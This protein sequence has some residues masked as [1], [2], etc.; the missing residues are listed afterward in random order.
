[1]VRISGAS[2]DSIAQKFGAHRDAIWR[3]M[4]NHVSED[5]KAAYL[6]DAPLQEMAAKAAAEGV[7]LIHYFSL[8]RSTVVQQ[9][10][11][12]ASVNDRHGLAALSGRAI[13]VTREVGKLTGELM[14]FAPGN[15]VNNLAVFVASPVFHDLQEMLLDKLSGHPD[16][17]TAVV[18]GLREL[19]AKSGPSPAANG[20]HLDLVALPAVARGFDAHA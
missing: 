6:A 5:Q 8:I 4:K 15:T 10:L 14:Q 13:E 12:A 1:M 7:S 2:L 19:E 3:H 18:E 9:M 17:L 11:L 16:A 20:A